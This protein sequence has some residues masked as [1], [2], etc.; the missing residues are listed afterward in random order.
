M[1]TFRSMEEVLAADLPLHHRKVLLRFI[2][3]LADAYGSDF[4]P[5]LVEGVILL[6]QA[7]TDSHALDLFGRTWPEV[8]YEEVLYDQ[9]SGCFLTCVLCNGE[10]GVTIVVPDEPWLDPALRARLAK[11]MALA[12]C[13]AKGGK[14]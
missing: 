9:P 1:K 3:N 6:D 12:P 5:E 11:R 10:E 13:N 14:P 2:Q 4:D 8:L 7:T